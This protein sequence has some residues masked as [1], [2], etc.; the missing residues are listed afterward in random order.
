MQ[1]DGKKYKIKDLENIIEDYQHCTY[2]IDCKSCKAS[3][4]ISPHISWCRFLMLFRS[5]VE[6]KFEALLNEI[7]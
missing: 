7:L 4:E 2:G 5:K 1:K 6:D 3:Q